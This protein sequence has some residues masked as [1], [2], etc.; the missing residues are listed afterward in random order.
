MFMTMP[1]VVI[2]PLVRI[3][4]EPDLEQFHLLLFRVNVASRLF[5]HPFHIIAVM[6]VAVMM[7][8]KVMVMAKMA[9]V[10]KITEMP[11]PALDG[12]ENCFLVAG[13]CHWNS[14]HHYKQAQQ[15]NEQSD[16]GHRKAEPALRVQSNLTI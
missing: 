15:A 5:Q 9:V 1:M 7:V 4:L 3:P 2:L 14:Q 16:H 6:V 11:I 10:A 12:H 8:A 13:L